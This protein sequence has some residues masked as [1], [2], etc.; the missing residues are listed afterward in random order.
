MAQQHQKL[1]AI[2]VIRSGHSV[3]CWPMLPQRQKIDVNKTMS[4]SLRRSAFEC[5]VPMEDT[6]VV[7]E[8]NRLAWLKETGHRSV[9]SADIH[10]IIQK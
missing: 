7:S 9:S 1:V 2:N 10:E 4:Y 3:T 5:R 6:G 8:R